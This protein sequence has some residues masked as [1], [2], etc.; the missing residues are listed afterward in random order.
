MIRKNGWRYGLLF[1]A[2][3][4]IVFLLIFVLPTGILIT[5]SFTEWDG[6]HTPEWV[7]LANYAEMFRDAGFL[8]SLRNTLSMGLLAAF[9]H[10]PLGTILAL[11]LYRRPV[12]WKVLRSVS[13]I[14]DIIS[15]SVK[16]VIFVFVFNPGIG[17]LNGFVRLFDPQFAINW[18]YNKNTAF[19][20]V[21]ATWIFHFGY[22][23]LITLSELQSLPV[24]YRESAQ[25][26][27]ASSV[28]IDLYIHLPLI[29]H[30]V[31]SCMILMVTGM[32]KF[33]EQIYL[34]TA[35]GPGYTTS[36]LALLIY[37]N[38]TTGFRYGYGNAI[39]MV[40]M[41]L[42]VFVILLI[43]KTMRMDRSFAQ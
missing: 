11:F 21:T 12:G 22:V 19:W 8:Q 28:Q 14:P 4:L 17:L 3:A 2:P 20:A 10:V 23:L 29:R 33:F 40:L 42:G 34:T 32:F 5:T 16:A 9:V 39:G 36:T 6:K 25:L 38:M 1:A 35:G 41:L 26:D 24:S 7:G 37:Q 43:Q 15:S 27:G 13:M 31:G 18:F 30:T